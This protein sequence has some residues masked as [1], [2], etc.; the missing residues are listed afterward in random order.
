LEGE[1]E[2]VRG[3]ERRMEEEGDR[4]LGNMREGEW[5]NGI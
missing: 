3:K 4:R 5:R 2:T 1:R